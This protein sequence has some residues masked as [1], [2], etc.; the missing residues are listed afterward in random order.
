MILVVSPENKTEVLEDLKTAG[1]TACVVGKLLENKGREGC[2]IAG[3]E[4]WDQ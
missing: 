1:E 3:M 2:V 4:I